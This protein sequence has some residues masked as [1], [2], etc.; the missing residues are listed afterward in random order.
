MELLKIQV[1]EVF[2]WNQKLVGVVVFE[3]LLLPHAYDFLTPQCRMV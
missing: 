3:K 1:F 2:D